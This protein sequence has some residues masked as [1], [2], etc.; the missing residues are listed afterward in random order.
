MWINDSSHLQM[1]ELVSFDITKEKLS[2]LLEVGNG[3]PHL[4]NEIAWN[5]TAQ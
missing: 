5:K 2:Q 4:V 3:I 1:N